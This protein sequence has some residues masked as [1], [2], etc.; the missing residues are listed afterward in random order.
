MDFA[1]ILSERNAV[2]VNSRNGKTMQS[3]TCL[4]QCD[5]GQVV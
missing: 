4:E 1:L 5:N 3:D 2:V